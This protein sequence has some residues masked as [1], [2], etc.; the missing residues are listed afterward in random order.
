MRNIVVISLMA[1]SIGAA[2]ASNAADRQRPIGTETTIAFAGG[3]GLRNW[4]VGP[5]GTNTVFVQDLQLRWYRVTL[6]GP[7]AERG[8]PGTLIYTTDNSG[9][10][11]RFSRVKAP[12][13]SLY[14]ACGV[15]SIKTSL[16]PKGQPGYKP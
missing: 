9:T 1:A 15:T 5:R 16:P 7:C 6:T 12:E 8:D 2:G 14:G 4:Q 11:D 10:F 13:N 3:G